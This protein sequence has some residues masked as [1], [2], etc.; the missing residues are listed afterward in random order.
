MLTKLFK[1]GDEEALTILRLVLGV[2]FLAHGAQEMLGRFRGYGFSASMS[3][4][5]QQMGIPAPLAFLAIAAEFFG[6]L[7]LIVGLLSRIA[8]FGIA[9][10]M[11]VAVALVHARYG[12]FMNWLGNQKGEGI[13]YHLLAFAIAVT[14]ILK[15]GG[16]FSLDR[17]L[18]TCFPEASEGQGSKVVHAK[19]TK[20]QPSSESKRAAGLLGG[21]E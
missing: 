12:L 21:G 4:F 19:K 18:W 8:A 15:G 2:I 20:Q 17:A 6:G 10:N 13:E 1:A 3:F 11:V 5:T 7:G 9:T 14:V 16:A